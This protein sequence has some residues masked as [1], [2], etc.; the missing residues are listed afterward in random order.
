MNPERLDEPTEQTRVEE[1]L[2]EFFALSAGA[3][4]TT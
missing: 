3:Y 1:K 2:K 4:T